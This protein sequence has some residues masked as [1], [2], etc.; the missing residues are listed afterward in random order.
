MRRFCLPL[1]HWLETWRLAEPEP[2]RE[3]A[4]WY[5]LMAAQELVTVEQYRLAVVYLPVSVDRQQLQAELSP[6]R[7]WPSDREHNRAA[8]QQQTPNEHT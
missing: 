8:A 4:L 7:V 3:Q 6:V 5:Q 1:L 2:A